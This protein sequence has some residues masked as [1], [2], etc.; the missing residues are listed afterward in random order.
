MLDPAAVE[1]RYGQSGSA[2]TLGE[3]PS[4]KNVFENKLLSI[5]TTLPI[6]RR[7]P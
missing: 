5:S 3:D 2:Q 1:L 4:L 6:S 7:F